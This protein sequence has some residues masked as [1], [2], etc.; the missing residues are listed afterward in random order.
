VLQSLAPVQQRLRDDGRLIVLVA[1]AAMLTSAILAWLA[2]GLLLRPLQR[3]RHGAAKLRP[4]DSD[5]QRLPDPG[6]Q[7][8]VTEL[9]AT[10]N[11]MLER[12]QRSMQATRRFTADAGHELRSPLASLGIDLETLRHNPDL[13]THRRAEMLDA[14]SDEHARIAA[15]P[16]HFRCAARPTSPR[17]PSRPLAPPSAVIPAF[18]TASSPRR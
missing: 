4:G 7:Q 8:E 12:L 14:M 16:K 13:P 1:L 9:T 10:L 18:G 6:G 3:L 2:A 5:D 15:T 11:A 17:S